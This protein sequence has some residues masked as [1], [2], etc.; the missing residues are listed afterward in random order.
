MEKKGLVYMIYSFKEPI[1]E[2]DITKKFINLIRLNKHVK[3]YRSNPT[4]AYC[5]REFAKSNNIHPQKVLKLGESSMIT[6]Y[7]QEHFPIEIIENSHVI[8]FHW[9]DN[10]STKATII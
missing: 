9:V 2:K 10:H 4:L 3:L 1:S 6:T 5:V 7:L 8:D